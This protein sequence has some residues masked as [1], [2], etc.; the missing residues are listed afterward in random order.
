ML[1]PYGC[2]GPGV[3]DFVPATQLPQ[4]YLHMVLRTVA[5]LAVQH[6]Q[7]FTIVGWHKKLGWPHEGHS[8]IQLCSDGCK[9]G[10]A[11]T[12]T[13]ITDIEY[14]EVQANQEADKYGPT[15]VHIPLEDGRAAVAIATCCG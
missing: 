15:I 10:D 11:G 14:I 5:H 1:P 2:N 9:E 13:V 12:Y 3:P 6:D 8:G 7:K 4:T